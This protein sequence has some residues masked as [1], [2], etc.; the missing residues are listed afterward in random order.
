MKTKKPISE[1]HDNDLITDYEVAEMVDRKRSAVAYW[2][3]I[4]RGPPYIK[5]TER[6]VRY[7]VGDVRAWLTSRTVKGA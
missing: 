1:L 6:T 2:R 3:K 7:R 5:V 4:R